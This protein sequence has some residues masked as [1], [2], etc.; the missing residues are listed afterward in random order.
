MKILRRSGEKVL[1][2]PIDSH[3]SY[4]GL[5]DNGKLVVT[6]D[7]YTV[8]KQVLYFL[9]LDEADMLEIAKIPELHY[10]G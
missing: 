8:D 7:L 10:D 6:C 2:A 5:D 9:Q 3:N 1:E 4:V